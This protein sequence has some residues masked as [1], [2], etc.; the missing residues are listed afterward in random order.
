[1]AKAYLRDKNGNKVPLPCIKGEKGDQMFVRFSAYPDGTDMAETWD[2]SRAYMGYAF[3]LNAPTDKSGYA[4][5]NLCVPFF[6]QHGVDGDFIFRVANGTAEKPSNAMTIDAKGNMEVSGELS[7]GEDRY[8]PRAAAENLEKKIDGVSKELTTHKEGA[9]KIFKTSYTGFGKYGAATER[10]NSLTVDF[11]IKF[12]L[13]Q[14][15]AK[16]TGL[17]GST[18]ASPV[19]EYAF[20]IAGSHSMHRIYR[21]NSSDAVEANTINA[22]L[23]EDGRTIT[24]YSMESDRKQMNEGNVK[25]LCI[26][27]G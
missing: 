1:M 13:I 22:E 11:P 24:W 15:Q 3:G 10:R 18:S 17:T 16:E 5:I 19:V 9:A 26:V 27:A 21:S 7:Y 4:W 6:G 14:S 2:S 25:Y 20:Y 8:S 12:M 23:S